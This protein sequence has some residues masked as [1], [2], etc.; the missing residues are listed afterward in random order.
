MQFSDYVQNPR[1]PLWGRTSIAT[2]IIAGTVL[3]LSLVFAP[4]QA[5]APSSVPDEGAR[6]IG[7]AVDAVDTLDPSAFQHYVAPPSTVTPQ[8]NRDLGSYSVEIVQRYSWPTPGPTSSGF[9]PRTCAPDSPCSTFHEGL[10]LTP[11]AGTSV[12]A[13]A[14]GTVRLADPSGTSDFGVY[15]I[16][17]HNVDGVLV[18]TLYAHLQQGSTQVQPG[19]QVERGQMLGRVGDTGRSYGAHLHFEVH[20][21]GQSVSPQQWMSSHGALPYPAD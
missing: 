6:G 3:A 14:A 12:K 18:S 15:V 21:N 20:V 4:A 7:R 5:A 17:D 2:R 16:V 9:G 13:V 1:A 8:L 11:G 10:D 19:Q